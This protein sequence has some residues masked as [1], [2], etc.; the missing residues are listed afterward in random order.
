MHIQTILHYNALVADLKT[1]INTLIVFCICIT[2]NDEIWQLIS[3]SEQISHNTKI[4]SLYKQHKKII[5]A[6]TK[7]QTFKN[8][9]TV[10]RAYQL[11]MWHCHKHLKCKRGTELYQKTGSDD[12]D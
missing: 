12:R 9:P 3:D 4:Q 10:I 8:K 11:M 5:Q 1:D 2:L 6:N 7:P